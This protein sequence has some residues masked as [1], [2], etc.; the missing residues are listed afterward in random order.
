MK[1]FLVALCFVL[2]SSTTCLAKSYSFKNWGVQTYTDAFTDEPYAL[3]IGRPAM[4]DT[5][6]TCR[7]KY[8]KFEF[9]VGKFVDFGK[10]YVIVRARVDS[11]APIAFIGQLDSKSNSAGEVLE[12]VTDGKSVLDQRKELRTLLAQMKKGQK[13]LIQVSQADGDNAAR[14]YQ[15]LLGFTKAYNSVRNYCE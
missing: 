2:L 8:V 4:H 14:D 10:S 13:L 12:I 6:I 5:R 11:M 9:N 1:G 3:L 15:S 7:G